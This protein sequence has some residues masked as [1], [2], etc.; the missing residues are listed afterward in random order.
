MFAKSDDAIAFFISVITVFTSGIAF[1]TSQMIGSAS[2]IDAVVN[3]VEKISDVEG[4]AEAVDQLS[5]QRSE[6]LLP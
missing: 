5:E 1:S 2:V 4:A 3:S 6:G